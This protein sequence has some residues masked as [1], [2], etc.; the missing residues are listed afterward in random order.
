M[1][2]LLEFLSLSAPPTFRLHSRKFGRQSIPTRCTNILAQPKEK[3][4]EV[5]EILK[6]LLLSLGYVKPDGLIEV[7]RARVRG[8]AKS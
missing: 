6:P 2:R 3:V 7:A 8:L 1:R 5:V 4:R